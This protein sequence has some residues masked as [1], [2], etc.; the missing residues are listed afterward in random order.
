MIKYFLIALLFFSNTHASDIINITFLGTG[1]PRPDINKLGPSVL[2]KYANEELLLDAG[3]GSALRINQIGNDFSKINNIFISHMHYDHIIGIADLWL[4]SNL[5]QRKKDINIFGPNSI[6]SFCDNLMKSYSEDIKYR[7]KE[8]NYS[9]LNCLKFSERNHKSNNIEIIE[10]TNN[11]GHIDNSYGFKINYK[12][13]SIVYSGD[14]TYSEN[15]IKNSMNADI[16]IHEVIA[17]S[18]KIYE[19]NHK[20]KK[21]FS[22]HTSIEQL[23]KILSLCKPKLTILNHALLFGISEEKVLSEIRKNYSGDVIF[24]RDLMSV[25]LGEEI[26]I[27]NIGK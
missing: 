10:F 13:K 21:V 15:V 9:K 5:W 2:I 6:K 12:N 25:D 22:T 3:R 4:T 24:S 19:S 8:N 14:T 26:N 23:V 18:P 16:L 11:H 20:L 27:F 17:A 7:Y 1:T